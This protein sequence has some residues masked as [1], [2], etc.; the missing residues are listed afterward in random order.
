[1][2]FQIQSIFIDTLS[3]NFLLPHIILP[4]RISKTSALIDNIF[5][6]WTSLE[7]IETGNVT[8][9]FSVY[10]PQFILLKDFFSKITAV[11]LNILKHDC[12]KFESNKFISDFNQTDC[13]Q[14]LCSEKSDVKFSMNQ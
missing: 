7:E 3:S 12:K 9:T 4:T 8:S 11:K 13:N 5:S 6:N 1:M 2:N 14:I 10:L